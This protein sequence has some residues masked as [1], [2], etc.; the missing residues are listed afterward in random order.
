MIDLFDPSNVITMMFN[1]GK[2]DELFNYCKNLL[3]KDPS[4]MLALQNISLSLIPLK[5]IQ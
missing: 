2:Y 4:D 5:K 3:E 1:N